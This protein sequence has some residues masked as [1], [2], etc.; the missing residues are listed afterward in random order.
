MVDLI[1]AKINDPQFVVSVLVAIAAAATVLTLAM[2]L[3]QT[4][5]LGR[6]MKAVSL[7]A[8]THPSSASANA[9]RSR[10]RPGD[11][12]RRTKA[13]ASRMSST[14]CESDE[15]GSEPN[16]A[17]MQL[18]MAGYRGAQAPGYTF[19]FFRLVTPVVLFLGTG[20][21]FICS[22]CCIGTSRR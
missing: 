1:V 8:G 10:V 17:K 20:G 13:A 22:C 5:N 18:A 19:L 2:P 15:T 4:D 16:G 11:A 9:W 6:R 3:L 14:D 12:A 21:C 7:R